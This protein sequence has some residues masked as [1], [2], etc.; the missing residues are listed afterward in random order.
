MSAAAWSSRI[1]SVGGLLALLAAEAHAAEPAARRYALLVG[2]NDGGP[3]RTRLK[4]AH[5]DARQM[6]SVLSDL[7]GV[8]PVD[9][10]LVFDPDASGL[11]RALDDLEAALR[12]DPPDAR[13]EVLF[14]YSGH[15]D[16]QGLLLGTERFAYTDL[17][18]RLEALPADVRVGVLDSC[19]SGALV[20]GKGGR[21]IAPFLLDEASA[22][23]GTAF[24]TSAS[25]D[26][27]AQEADVIGG[28]FFTFH[29]VSAMRGAA[30]TDGDRRV[31]LGE[32][33]RYAFDETLATTSTTLHGAQHA[34]WDLDL[35]GTGD[36]VLT[37][38]TRTAASV[39]LDAPIDAVVLVRDDGG[40]I[41]AEFAKR[42]DLPVELGVSAG[43]YVLTL[44]KDGRYANVPVAVRH[45]ESA[46]VYAA[47]VRWNDGELAVARGGTEDFA[48][49]E[50]RFRFQWI[51]TDDGY[52]IEDRFALSVLAGRSGRLR[53]V[54]VALGAHL[55]DRDAHGA[56]FALGFN[57]VGGDLYG[58]QT[59]LGANHTGGHAASQLALG[60]NIAEGGVRGVQGALGVNIADG[61]VEGIQI[62]MG[63]NIASEPVRGV[64][65]SMGVN[66]AGRGVQGA[67]IG[68]VNVA[69]RV[70]GLQ[71][72]L[73]NVAKSSPAPIGLLSFIE[74]GRHDLSI[75][76]SE[77]GLVN[78]DFKLGGQYFHTIVGAGFTPDKHL[79][80]GLG[81]GTQPVAR[82]VFLDIDVS[83]L[84]IEPWDRPF[85]DLENTYVGR[86][87]LG[88]GVPFTPALAL[89]AG[90]SLNVRTYTGAEPVPFPAAFIDPSGTIAVVWPGF[91]AGIQVF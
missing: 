14:Y 35:S 76:G 71:I 41:V 62:A 45:G 56:M 42:P 90:A 79:W 63:G 59:A 86:G 11:S 65:L 9:R 66:I 7:G 82:P 75:Y 15:S 30:D 58:L 6:G 46:T 73:I 83:V 74:E 72:G 68:F 24:L 47:D 37:D 44:S 5:D 26:E 16:A 17:R 22:V 25:A 70:Q 64:Q 52:Q 60:A 84:Q 50:E 3:Y 61:P 78:A 49:R 91:Y 40:R 89:F 51:P 10:T 57:H 77:S 53:G 18:A 69:G 88:L 33:Y 85:R 12:D 28:S 54:S 81:L 80:V 87:R 20:R 2:A 34:A 21:P 13:T 31:T 4:Y 55:V 48:W 67:Q 27:E 23:S 38:L 8:S 32:A 36:L 1:A 29:L 19:A 43:K 39:V